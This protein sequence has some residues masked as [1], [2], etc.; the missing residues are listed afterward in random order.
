MKKFQVICLH[1]QGQS[2]L[3]PEDGNSALLPYQ[4]FQFF[5]AYAEIM[6]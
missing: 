4:L 6:L 3:N 1:H 5:P 2:N